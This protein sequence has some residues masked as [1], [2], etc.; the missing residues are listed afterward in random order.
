LVDHYRRF[1][2]AL[3]S[4]TRFSINISL[5]ERPIVIGFLISIL[6]GQVFPVMYIATFFELLWIDLIPAGTFIPPN[7]IFCVV[8]TATLVQI[9]GLET[10]SQVFPLMMAAI[11]VAFVCAWLEGLQR[12]AQNRNYNL[13]LQQSRRN[14]A[15]Y[16][17]GLIVRNSILQLLLI[18]LLVGIS[19]I[20]G[21]FVLMN[22]A[23]PYLPSL[24]HFSWHILLMIASL[25]A[26][27]ALRA[28]RAYI[29]LLLGLLM[30]SGYFAWEMLTG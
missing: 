27:A 30:V 13:I 5:L 29:S 28:R 23:G 11:P 20:Y 9:S 19:G 1:F 26:L 12:N 3:F 22:A 25:S 16:W 10:A 18:Y 7:A 17:P 14:P 21:L 15:Q 24:E 6:T 8:A 4:L 2:F